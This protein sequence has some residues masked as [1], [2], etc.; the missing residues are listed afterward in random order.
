LKQTWLLWLSLLCLLTSF[1]LRPVRGATSPDYAIGAEDVLSISVWEHP[2]LSRTAAVQANGRISIPPLG[3]VPAAGTTTTALAR[4]LES[5]IYNTLRA[6][7]QV[8]VSVIAFNSQK[9]YL[10]GAVQNPGRYTF[11]TLPNL[12]DLLG[13]TGGLSPQADLTHVRVL[14]QEGGSTQTLSVDLSRAVDSGDLSGV[15]GLH[16][17]DLVMVSG[18]GSAVGAA[19]GASVVYVTGDVNK[20][21]PYNVAPGMSV[22]QVL[23]VAGG[24]T[25]T[26]DLSRVML[27]AGGDGGN[28]YRVTVDLEQEARAGS[29]GLE[30]RPGDTV[31]VPSRGSNAFFTGWSIMRETLGMSQNILN[32]FL[33]RDVLK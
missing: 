11:E 5:R 28:G 22:M 29:G 16:S 10:A 24:A 25:A 31:V 8:T 12:V 9:V 4:D 14:R 30:I 6:T 1:A 17:G 20:P 32:L 23:S 18:L 13:M 2:E 19:V 33:I 21:G 15:P 26:A 3:D 7:T 27:L